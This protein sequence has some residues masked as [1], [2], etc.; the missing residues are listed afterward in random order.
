MKLLMSWSLIP[1]VLAAVLSLPA[2]ASADDK[3]QGEDKKEN[4]ESRSPFADD[5]LEAAVRDE[6]KKKPDEKLTEDD[7]EDVY[8][9]KARGRG[10]ESLKGLEKCVNLAL[11]HLPDNKIKELKPLAGLVDIQSLDLAGNRIGD[12][13]P[14]SG[15]KKLQYLKLTGNRVKDL[16]P[17]K[18]LEKLSA[19]YLEK[20]NVQSLEPLSGLKKLSSLYL[21]DNE[22]KDIAPL[23][24]LTWLSSLDLRNNRIEN[25]SPLKSMTELRYTF[26]N[27]NKIK[28]IT[29]LVEMARKDAEG[30]KRFAPY[31]HLDLRGNP[32]NDAAKEQIGK[33]R[34]IGVRVQ[35]DR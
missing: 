5:N 24:N 18:N 30:E 21:A 11:L 15:L 13:S 16:E 9:L 3:D 25:V 17:L 35:R 23:A 29:P 33:L 32:L 12:L 4:A 14:L 27:G 10:I 7:L 22:I 8:V 28:D 34:E 26:L 20:N 19:L 2:V 31:W 6:L 1:T